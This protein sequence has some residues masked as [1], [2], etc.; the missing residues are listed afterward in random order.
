MKGL[1][2]ILMI[3]FAIFFY[4]IL[5]QSFDK[6]IAN[7]D[8]ML[9]ESAKISGNSDYLSKCGCYYQSGDITCLQASR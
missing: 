6:V 7:Q 5:A 2:V 1:I 3:A 4:I 8:T 9:C